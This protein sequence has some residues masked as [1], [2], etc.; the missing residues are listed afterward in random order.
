MREFV[1]NH[2][3]AEASHSCYIWVLHFVSVKDTRDE[4]GK[5]VYCYK[6]TIFNGVIDEGTKI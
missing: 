4:N 2:P 5:N 3:T 1:I 6:I